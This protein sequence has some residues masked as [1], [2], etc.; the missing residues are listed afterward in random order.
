MKKAILVLIVV[1]AVGIF[2]YG[3]YKA[4]SSSFTTYVAEVGKVATST[5]PTRLQQTESL[6]NQLTEQRK[7]DQSF[8]DESNKQM[9]D[10]KKRREAQA[11]IDALMI[12]KTQLD[13]EISNL[14][15]IDGKKK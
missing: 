10:L 5:V 14:E 11:R 12:V 15:A 2:G 9:E 4:Q 8:I 1:G 3:A 13:V 6:I 7:K